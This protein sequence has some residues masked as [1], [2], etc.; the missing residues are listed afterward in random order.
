MSFPSYSAYKSSG[1]AFLGE[2][3]S[4]WTVRRIKAVANVINGYPFDSAKFSDSTGHQLI[5][6]RDLNCSDTATKF[7]GEFL[8]GAAVTNDDVLIG[9]DGDFNVGRW[10]SHEKALLNQRMCCIRTVDKLLSKFLYYL[11]PFPL[12]AINDVTYSTTVKHLSSFQVEKI[13]VATP[14]NY[15][16]LSGLVLFIDREV[17][18]IDSLIAEQERLMEIL[19]EKRKAVIFHSVTKGIDQKIKFKDS[20]VEWI[21]LIPEHWSVARVFRI[22]KLESGHT[23][24]K[25]VPEYW[26]NCTIPWVSLND[27]KQLAATDYITETAYQI[28]EL[29]MANSSAH[30]LEAGA[31]VFTRDATIGL[32]AIT[33]RKMA[34]SQH[35]IAWCPG[36]RI[37]GLFLLRVFNAMKDFLDSF[38]FGATIKTIGMADVK[39]LFTT[40]P[41]I[42]EQRAI[43]IHIDYELSKI[44]ALVVEV[45]KSILL[46]RERRS[47]LIASAVTGKI[48]VRGLVKQ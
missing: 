22:A 15:D 33:T 32:A 25:Q 38:T 24:S 5:R 14:S 9:M 16:E 12:N 37:D 20:G 35:L 29:G 19:A 47:A 42:E 39:K 8:D 17:S 45:E 3:P 44:D 27:S 4:H 31:V 21:G 11:L 43:A 41:P 18:K 30:L 40:L 36:E 13:C 23:P 34:V 2:I 10:M 7:N 46:M 28:S 6:I 1:D 26:E 48:D